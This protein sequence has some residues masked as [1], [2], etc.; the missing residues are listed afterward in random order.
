[1]GGAHQ[2]GLAAEQMSAA[3]DVQHQAMRRILGDHGGE[4]AEILHHL[5]KQ[6]GI[7]LGPVND[8]AQGRRSRPRIGQGQAGF[9]TRT[10]RRRINGG[11]TQGAADLL[12]Q[13][14]RLRRY[15]ADARP[16]P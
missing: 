14:D 7:R 1:M 10:R 2:S 12:D 16:T 8:G 6:G 5:Q 15:V 9:Q 13:D 3:G 11:Q 4:A